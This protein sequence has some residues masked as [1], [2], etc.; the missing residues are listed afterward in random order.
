MTRNPFFSAFVSKGPPDEGA[1][2]RSED[3]EF[4]REM[5]DYYRSAGL[6]SAAA[7]AQRHFERLAERRARHAVGRR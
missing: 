6:E 7:L 4:W 5:R 2:K 1:P 3:F